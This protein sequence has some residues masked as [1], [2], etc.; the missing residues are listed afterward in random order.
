M[1]TFNKLESFNLFKEVR[2]RATAFNCSSSL[3]TAFAP[4]YIGKASSPSKAGVTPLNEASR[5]MARFTSIRVTS[6]SR[7]LLTSFS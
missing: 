7:T 3:P 6:I 5:C 4:K 2:T 1:R